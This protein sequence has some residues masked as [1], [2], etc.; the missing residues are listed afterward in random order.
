MTAFIREPTKFTD[1]A[2]DAG[3]G[4][5]PLQSLAPVSSD[6]DS[7]VVPHVDNGV[8]LNGPIAGTSSSG[9]KRKHSSWVF[10]HFADDPATG[11]VMC[12]VQVCGTTYAKVSSTSTLALHLKTK[13]GLTR[14]GVEEFVGDATGVDPNLVAVQKAAK[15]ARQVATRPP[16]IVPPNI[17]VVTGALVGNDTPTGSSPASVMVKGE[18]NGEPRAKKRR[19][20]SWV[21]NHFMEDVAIGRVVCMFKGCGSNYAKV[22]STSTLA[23]H[24]RTRHNLSKGENGAISHTSDSAASANGSNK[25]SD[26]LASRNKLSDVGRADVFASLIN[27]VVHEKQ[28]PQIMSSEPFQDFCKKLNRFYALPSPDQLER[29][30]GDE[31]TRYQSL[32]R[33]VIDNIPGRVSLTCDSW[34]PH[35]MR[36]Y[37]AI[38]AHWIDENWKLNSCVIGIKYFPAPRNEHAMSELLL[39]LIK[40]YNL[41]TKIRSI[42][43]GSSK[44]M[45][46]AMRLVAEALNA[47]YITGLDA[48]WHIRCVSEIITHAV[49]ECDLLMQEEVAKLRTILQIVHNSEPMQAMFKDVQTRLG[50]APEE[51]VDVPQL[52]NSAQWNSTFGMIE[53]C[54][55]VRNVFEDLCNANEFKHRLGSPPTASEWRTLKAMKDF[56]EPAYELT[57]QA[58][59]GMYTTLSMQP[60]I[61]ESLS[62]HCKT[63]IDENMG[64]GLMSSPSAVKGARLILDKLHEY[65]LYLASPLAQLALALDPAIPNAVNEVGYMKERIRSILARD[66]GYEVDSQSSANERKPRK[67]LLAI[68]RAAR[69][70]GKDAAGG[71]YNDEVEDFFEFTAKGDESCTDAVEW[72]GTIGVK[73]FPA[74]APLA[75]DTLVCMGSSMPSETSSTD[76]GHIISGDATLLSS[77]QIEQTLKLRSWKLLLR[78][79]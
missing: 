42:T 14:D 39:N 52:D 63:M 47:Q 60:L 67:G 18:D 70:P 20:S 38:S 37:I 9:R 54:Y 66:Y 19:H 59:A 22:S 24:L 48:D 44:E 69:T 50:R 6:G 35:I 5:V 68:A 56:L 25:A 55:N 17:P 41:H 61:L 76:S 1:L 33:M 40:E 64:A 71:F 79:L 3:V 46:P 23:L 72:W 53:S 36:G 11:R 73:R 45:E 7:G 49:M 74:L 51:I 28:S 15:M 43:T 34:S 27:W 12:M 31:Y 29:G 32:V 30:I 62:N 26:R 57:T 58:T 8:M 10:N 13:H 4:H 75:R 65:R 78:Q 16:P 21:F 2:A 77:D